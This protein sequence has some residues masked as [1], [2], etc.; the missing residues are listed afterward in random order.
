MDESARA[1]KDRPVY[2]PLTPALR[3]HPAVS[4]LMGL[5]TSGVPLK[6]QTTH[7]AHAT[8]LLVRNNA[9]DS[10]LWKYG[11]IVAIVLFLLHISRSS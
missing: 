8:P 10:R 6:E 7:V 5:P 3:M 4:P 1:W 9:R 2:A 11:I